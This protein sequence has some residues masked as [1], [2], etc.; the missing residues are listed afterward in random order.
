[1]D[2]HDENN[3]KRSVDDNDINESKLPEQSEKNKNIDKKKKKKETSDIH[4]GDS[5]N[6]SFDTSKRIGDLIM[7]KSV[8]SPTKLHLK[9]TNKIDKS[10]IGKVENSK[11]EEVPTRDGHGS[12]KKEIHKT[13]SHPIYNNMNDKNSLKKNTLSFDDANKKI[14]N[15]KKDT[16]ELK[17]EQKSTS[18]SFK[19]FD[20]HGGVKSRENDHCNHNNRVMQDGNEKKIRR[21]VPKYHVSHK[22]KSISD[23]LTEENYSH[24]ITVFVGE[25]VQKVK[26]DF[27]YGEDPPKNMNPKTVFESV[28]VSPHCNDDSNLDAE[29]VIEKKQVK[30]V[31]VAQRCERSNADARA[32]EELVKK[33]PGH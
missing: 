32:G 16:T 30:T 15:E 6:E 27:K 25:K 7:G 26:A 21:F 10:S 11:T 19:K 31:F 2:S 9:S 5:P 28:N 18:D 13:H 4:H 20:S 23:Y 17:P 14:Y 8:D 12:M 24:R 1:M 22:I 29:R 33:T 3:L